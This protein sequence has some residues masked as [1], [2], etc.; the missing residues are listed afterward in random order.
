MKPYVNVCFQK[1]YITQG[2][3]KI[4][5]YGLI[6]NIVGLVSV[7]KRYNDELYVIIF[8]WQKIL[9][10][11]GIAKAGFHRVKTFF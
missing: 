3:R 4:V 6:I 8:T 5:Y 10:R 7:I 1:Q 11:Y 9:D 2:N